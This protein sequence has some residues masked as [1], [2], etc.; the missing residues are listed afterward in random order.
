[1]AEFESLRGVIADTLRGLRD[2]PA[3][4]F[5]LRAA[6]RRAGADLL[7]YVESTES[8][9]GALRARIDELRA[10]VEAVEVE[11]DELRDDLGIANDEYAKL[12]DWVG[13]W[14]GQIDDVDV[15][16]EARDDLRPIIEAMR[17][18]ASAKP[19]AS[20]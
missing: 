1:M 8:G 2:S 17:K 11:R 9:D 14:A 15:D 20:K 19:K 18:V 6:R 3:S 4:L 7:D 5:D 16:S 13:V 12:R 10:Q